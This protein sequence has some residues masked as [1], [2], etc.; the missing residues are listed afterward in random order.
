MELK[1]QKINKNTL[2]ITSLKN[3]QIYGAA[4]DVTEPEPIPDDDPL[5]TLDNCIIAP[6]I[7][8]ASIEARQEM[9]RIAAQNLING[10]QGKKLLE[11]VNPEVYAE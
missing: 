9:S 8:S 4:L 3:N 1:Y 2:I 5:L 6:H 10:L 7:A 11:C